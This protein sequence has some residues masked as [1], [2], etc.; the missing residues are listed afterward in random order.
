MEEAYEIKTWKNPNQD[1][2]RWSVREAGDRAAFA[3]GTAKNQLAARHA[4]CR[5]A[6]EN[7][8]YRYAK[9]KPLV[10]PPTID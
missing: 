8:T 2:L 3:D 6:E 4:A 5:A 1:G 10:E 7:E 9:W